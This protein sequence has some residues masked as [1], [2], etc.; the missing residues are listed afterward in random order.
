MERGLSSHTIKSYR[1]TIKLFFNYLSKIKNKKVSSLNLEDLI[2]EN[3]LSFLGAIEKE[4]GNSIRTRNQRLAV[5]KTFFTY[6]LSQDV[7]RANQYSK[8][9]HMAMKRMPYKPI[10][11]LTEAEVKA[12]FGAINRES[13]VGKRNHVILMILYNTGARVQEVCDLKL[14]DIRLEEP[15]MIS[16][17][18][19]GNK[20]RQVP[21]WKDTAMSI[22]NFL[23]DFPK[24]ENG[25][26]IFN[27]IRNTP[28]SRFGIR[29]VIRS[30][31]KKAEKS[32]P[33]LKDKKI[34]PHTFRHTTAMH[35]LQSGV[36]IVVIK[37]WLGH[38]DLNTTHNYIEIDMKMK[39]AALNKMRSKIDIKNKVSNFLK[40]EKDVVEWLK[41]L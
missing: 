9:S 31:Y 41:E 34:G 35:L 38:V 15:F 32:C 24:Q 13:I 11:Y 5:I 7:E 22:K 12:F 30:L 25:D 36:D 8:I 33:T 3:V 27:G 40:K 23:E 17:T 19:K 4:R 10:T 26:K 29:S 21:L 18:G 28:L 16:L 1:D 6:L 2:V 20:T 14:S 37:T 39:E